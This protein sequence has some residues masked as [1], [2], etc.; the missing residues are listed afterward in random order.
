ME[1]GVRAVSGTKAE[2]TEY[3]EGKKKLILMPYRF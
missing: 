2:G 3:T 1:G